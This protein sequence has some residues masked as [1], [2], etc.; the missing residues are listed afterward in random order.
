[1]HFLLLTINWVCVCRDEEFEEELAKEGF[2]VVVDHCLKVERQKSLD[3]T[4]KF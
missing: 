4:S 3:I 1:M 2:K